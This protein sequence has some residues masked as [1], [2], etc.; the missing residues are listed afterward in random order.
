MAAGSLTSRPVVL[1]VALVVSAGLAGGAAYALVNAADD[2][3]TTTATGQPLPGFGPSP[4]QAPVVLPT[5]AATPTAAAT[6][7]PRATPTASPTLSPRTSPSP[8]ASQKPAATTAT[9]SRYP[10][11]AN[12]GTAAGLRLTAK[13]QAQGYSTTTVL[14]ITATDGDG[15]IT[16]GGL[17]WGD[18]TSVGPEAVPGHCPAYPS[19]T[20]A[21]GPY[22]PRGDERTFTYSH[23]Y[24]TDQDY[25]IN[26]TVKSGNDTCRPHGPTPESR[27]AALRVHFAGPSPT[28]TP[29]ATE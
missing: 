14:T 12:P 17:T 28:P 25:T 8:S 26:L 4:S 10:Y 5:D 19:P 9:V 18:G 27:S 15:N 1:G 29:A 16:F 7:T 3:G 20:A 11:P 23:T 13:S 6:A 22:Q 21:P 2:Q 24:P